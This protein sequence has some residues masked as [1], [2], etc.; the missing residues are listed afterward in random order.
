MIKKIFDKKEVKLII[1]S[2]VVLSFAFGFND[3]RPDFVLS[4]YLFNLVLVTILV[5]LSI[6]IIEIMIRLIARQY[7]CNI[8][9]QVWGIKR[10]SLRATLKKKI[11]LGVIFCILGAFISKGSF[12]FALVQNHLIK[13]NTSF[14]ALK[15]SIHISEF[16]TAVIYSIAPLTALVL[17]CIGK[18]LNLGLLSTINSYFAIFLILPFPAS[19]A[20][21]IL[22][23]AKFFYL[24]V[25]VFIVLSTIL[26]IY[27]GVISTIIIAIL[28]STIILI[29]SLFKTYK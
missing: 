26:L 11:P 1:L 21:K 8:Q 29:L 23:S 10:Y 20:I 9:H 7:F 19:D 17:V 28:A 25:L 5:A 2:I 16:E 18:I 13:E 27:T 4:Y 12:V 6:L 15:K 24:F 14:R 22:F 3:K